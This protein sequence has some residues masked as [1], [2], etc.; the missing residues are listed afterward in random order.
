VLLPRLTAV[1]QDTDL[2][3]AGSLFCTHH[4]N[5]SCQ[6]GT[7]MDSIASS[8]LASETESVCYTTKRNS[9]HE[10]KHSNEYLNINVAII[11]NEH[12]GK[13]TLLSALLYD[14]A[15]DIFDYTDLHGYNRF[16]LQKVKK[17]YSAA[18]KLQ[19]V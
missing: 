6:Q 14:T 7:T 2:D 1:A 8:Y 11:G 3:Q 15:K 10:G 18:T 4:H 17:C 13:T 16:E 12:S 19:V 9:I 5:Q